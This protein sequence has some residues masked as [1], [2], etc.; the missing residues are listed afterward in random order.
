MSKRVTSL[1]IAICLMVIIAAILVTVKDLSILP[2]VL[3]P[4]FIACLV[5]VIFDT[6]HLIKK[7]PEIQETT[8][9]N[10]NNEENDIDEKDNI[11][12]DESNIETIKQDKK[13]ID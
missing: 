8:Q 4:L 3:G 5:V 1:I 10:K 9:A 12:E 7:T 2:F 11:N 13:R 6:I